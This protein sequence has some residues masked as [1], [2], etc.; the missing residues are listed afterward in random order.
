M[1]HIKKN[2]EPSLFVEWKKDNAAIL[3]EKYETES[4]TVIWNWFGKIFPALRN[5]LRQA[6]LTEQGGICCYCGQD[7]SHLPTTIEHFHP[8]GVD[9]KNRIFDYPNLVLSCNY[10]EVETPSFIHFLETDGYTDLNTQRAIAEKA[11]CNKTLSKF[12]PTLKGTD[13]RKPITEIQ[14]GENLYLYIRHCENKKENTEPENKI[15]S[16]LDS[17]CTKYFEYNSDGKINIINT[18]DDISKNILDDVLNLNAA[19][20]CVFRVDAYG[21][22]EALKKR[23]VAEF[24]SGTITEDELIGEIEI[25]DEP[26][27]N[28]KRTPFCFVF[29]Y[30]LNQIA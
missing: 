21:K 3:Q 8:K 1:R 26:D 6:L 18:T 29:T 11:G 7:I 2:P 20:L 25:Q 9:T 12:N 28:G 16:P 13:P 30:L 24:D 4:G 15:I 5:D 17:D 23:L 27:G 22:A 14:K 19:N 10:S